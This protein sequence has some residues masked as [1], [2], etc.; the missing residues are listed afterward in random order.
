MGWI[1]PEKGSAASILAAKV[2]RDKEFFI[3]RSIVV[4]R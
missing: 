2:A 3:G 4:P 1:I